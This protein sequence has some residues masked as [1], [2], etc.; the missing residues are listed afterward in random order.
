MKT[1]VQGYQSSARPSPNFHP[2]ARPASAFGGASE[3]NFDG[4]LRDQDS[5]V[6]SPLSSSRI[7]ESKDEESYN[8]NRYN[9][10]RMEEDVSA[11]IM[12]FAKKR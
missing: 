12:N 3:L 11:V 4:H 5:D 1:Q 2:G 7:S 10:P 6:S 8:H 9:R